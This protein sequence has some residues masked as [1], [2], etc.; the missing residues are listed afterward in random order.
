MGT[1]PAVTYFGAMNILLGE[2]AMAGGRAVVDSRLLVIP[3]DEFRRL[4]RDEP[5]VLKGALRVIAPVQQGAE[6]VLREREKLVA[7]GTLSAGLAHELNN[8]AAAARR[9]ASDLAE[10]LEVIQDTLQRFVSSGVER[11]DA[12]ALVALHGEAVK[13][14]AAAG[15]DGGHGRRRPRGRPGRPARRARAGGLAPRRRP[16]P[17]PASTTSGSPASRGTPAPPSAPPS[18]GWWPRSARAAS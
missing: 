15:S 6:A 13:R 5:S 12:A 11:E 1:R 17:R 2:P 7:L 3:G 18:T 4:L 8:P 10:T 9:S 14:A 16:W